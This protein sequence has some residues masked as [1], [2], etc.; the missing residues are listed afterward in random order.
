MG[1]QRTI[2]AVAATVSNPL[3]STVPTRV[4]RQCGDPHGWDGAALGDG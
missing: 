1:R 4:G 3:S 2:N